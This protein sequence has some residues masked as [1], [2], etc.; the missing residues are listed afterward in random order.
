MRKKKNFWKII[1]LAGAIAVG[2]FSLASLRTE[3]AVD[4]TVVNITLTTLDTE[5]CHTVGAQGIAGF[6]VHTRNEADLKV[7]FTTG[8]SGTTYL[9]VKG[10]VYYSMDKVW[11]TN[12]QVICFQ[13]PT[14]STVVEMIIWE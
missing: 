10:G 12:T 9:T 1:V 11:M 14:A 3:R 4:P 13:S 2:V 7:A 8:Q 6:D 5:I